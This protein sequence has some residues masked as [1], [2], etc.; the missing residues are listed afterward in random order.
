MQA[1]LR[2]RPGWTKAERDELK[3]K[4]V[5]DGHPVQVR[6]ELRWIWWGEAFTPHFLP[7]PMAPDMFFAGMQ[8]RKVL[9]RAV[10][11]QSSAS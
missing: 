3:G 11:V 8:V 1:I 10:L 2:F 7:R 4:L 5:S 9:A 6:G